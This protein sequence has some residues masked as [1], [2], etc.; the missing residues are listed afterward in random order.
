[1]PAQS[2]FMIYGGRVIISTQSDKSVFIQQNCKT[3]K[4]CSCLRFHLFKI[5]IYLR[6]FFCMHI[7]FKSYLYTVVFISLSWSMFKG[8]VKSLGLVVKIRRRTENTYINVT[9]WQSSFAKKIIICELHRVEWVDGKNLSSCAL[10]EEIRERSLVDQISKNT[11]GIKQHR[12]MDESEVPYCPW[13]DGFWGLCLISCPAPPQM[14]WDFDSAI[15]GN[16]THQ[17]KKKRKKDMGNCT[18]RSPLGNVMDW[19]NYA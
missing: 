15:M 16:F 14:L 7:A 3:Q 12:S 13:K 9:M 1:M 8:L 5:Y 17:K 6:F 11:T 2:R 10:F 18:L 4:V 19:N